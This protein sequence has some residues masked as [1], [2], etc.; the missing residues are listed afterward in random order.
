MVGEANQL[1]L[2]MLGIKWDLSVNASRN[3]IDERRVYR[4]GTSTNAGV[5]TWR[6]DD[7]SLERRGK[8]WAFWHPNEK[9][10]PFFE[11]A[12]ITDH[13]LQVEAWDYRWGGLSNLIIDEVELAE[14]LSPYILE[15]LATQFQEPKM[16][17]IRGMLWQ[18]AIKKLPELTMEKQR[19]LVPVALSNMKAELPEV[20]SIGIR[21]LQ[22]E[23]TLK[24][25]QLQTVQ[26]NLQSLRQETIQKDGLLEQTKV[27][28]HETEK[29]CK[30]QQK[31][32][33]SAAD[34]FAYV[35]N[36]YPE[37]TETLNAFVAQY[38]MLDGLLSEGTALEEE[39]ASSVME[40]VKDWLP[41]PDFDVRSDALTQVVS[42]SL[43][44]IVQ[45]LDAQPDLLG[46][47][48]GVK[49]SS[50]LEHL[51]EHEGCFFQQEDAQVQ[52]NIQTFVWDLHTEMAEGGRDLMTHLRNLTAQEEALTLQISTASTSLSS[53]EPL[54]EAADLEMSR[55]KTT[56]AFLK[57]L[58][59]KFEVGTSRGDA[60][61]NLLDSKLA[62]FHDDRANTSNY[63]VGKIEAERALAADA[64]KKQQLWEVHIAETSHDCAEKL[65]ALKVA[66]ALLRESQETG[67]LAKILASAISVERARMAYSR[68]TAYQGQLAAAVDVHKTKLQA[69]ETWAI[70]MEDRW[71]K[72]R[73]FMDKFAQWLCDLYKGM[74]VKAESTVMA[75]REELPVIRA[76]FQQLQS[77]AQSD[78]RRREQLTHSALM[79]TQQQLAPASRELARL[80]RAGNRD[81]FLQVRCKFDQLKTEFNVLQQQMADLQE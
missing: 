57:L 59:S 68:A 7:Y 29:Q 14:E 41:M 60:L 23:V 42:S 77:A 8:A 15:V 73:D 9:D 54:P 25:K 39:M 3:K 5:P 48:F 56:L 53:G 21:L 50:Q 4:I 43:S 10:K 58:R 22:E 51:L 62:A 16:E 19:E 37:I 61:T 36:A 20:V 33:Q 27:L 45:F 66:Q 47:D 76:K 11:T 78:V 55:M 46:S 79:E 70:E 80:Q 24:D 31:Q 49:Q 28:Y 75:C 35:A 74:D 63:Y 6:A 64:K 65:E 81:E 72:G 17:K 2:P 13:P 26:D 12:E 34:R 40:K 69:Q 71:G 1:L 67:Q 18:A 32:L 52:K 38:S 30:L 44:R